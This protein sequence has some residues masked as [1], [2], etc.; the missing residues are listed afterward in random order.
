MLDIKELAANIGRDKFYSPRIWYLGSIPY[1]MSGEKAIA[2]EISYALNAIKGRRAKC[3]VLD[4]D[5]T[6]W[7]GVIGEDGI[8]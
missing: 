2:E 5:N 1:S 7:G 8:G 4:L 6:L 3:I